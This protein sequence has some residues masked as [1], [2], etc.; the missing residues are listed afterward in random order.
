MTTTIDGRT[1]DGAGVLA[2]ARPGPDGTCARAALDAGARAELDKARAYIDAHFMTDDAP[3]MY[4]FNTGVGLFK[5]Q[6][7]RMADMAEYQRR[8]VYAHATG[9]GEPFDADVVRATMLLRANAFASNYSGPR[10]VVVDEECIDQGRPGVVLDAL[11][12]CLGEH[13]AME[14]CTFQLEPVGHRPHEGAHHD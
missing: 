4:S 10:T 6:R 14:H 5:D 12:E 3:L 1:L 13:F 2:V 7:V 9:M 11:D 8:T